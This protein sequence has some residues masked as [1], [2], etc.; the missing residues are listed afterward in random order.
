MNGMS[1]TTF[2]ALR[3]ELARGGPAA[4]F[5]KLAEQLRSEKKYHDLFDAR[6]MEF[7]HRLGLPVILTSSLDDLPEPQRSQVEGAYLEACKEVGNLLLAE[8]R[9]RESWM[10]LRPVG[11]KPA[12]AKALAAIEPT[13]ENV[14]ELIEVSVHEGVD[15]A[16]GF[17]LVLGHYGV[18]NAITMFDATMHN[19]PRANR[20][21]VA[22]LLVRRLHGD[23]LRNLEAEITRQEGQP[24]A[25]K[26]IA[27]LV[28]DRD[29]LFGADNYHIDTSHLHAVVR[30]ARQVTDPETL[31]LAVDLT[32]YGRRLSRQFQYPGEE[33][34]VDVHPTHALFFRAQL[35]EEVNTAL[36]YF[37]GRAE[38]VD[39]AAQGA[40]AAEVYVALLT[41]LSRHAEAFD[42]MA[43]LVPAGAPLTGLAPTLS[44]LASTAGSY[45]QLMAVCQQRGDLLGF[46]AGLIEAGAKA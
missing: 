36:D 15:P 40:G 24:P 37:R 38:A 18:C 8:G 4:A 30:F 25:E 13:D 6:L 10:Y 23:L 45:E 43:R 32:E 28:A 44:E 41:R 33:P 14:Q 5:G 16:R 26:S 2:D 7:R 19:Q 22:R 34:F 46:T 39:A 27:G 21:A 42:A 35:G 9:I 29:W 20:Q 12:V 3:S 31:R 1:T 11:D 17:D